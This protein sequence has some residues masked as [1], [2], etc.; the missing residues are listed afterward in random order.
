MIG[1]GAVP[2]WLGRALCA[3]PSPHG[4]RKVLVAI[5]Q[6]GAAD[7]LNIVVPFRDKQYYSLR[8]TIAIPQPGKQ[9]GALD[10]D[11]TCGL[12]P[13]MEPLRKLFVESRLAIV[14]GA[15][16][17]DPTR[18][19]FDAQD[20]MESGTPGRKATRD[21]WLNRSL[22]APDRSDSPLRAV[23]MGPRLP[24][25]LRGGNSAVAVADIR[26]F[27]VKEGDAAEMLEEM[28]SS[29]SDRGL[30]GPGKDTFEALKLLESIRKQP[31]TPAEGA[32][33]PAGRFG[34]SLQQI[35]RLI[36]AGAGVEV[37]FADLGGWDHHVNEPVQLGNLLR[38]FAGGLA[39]FY[40]DLG[41]AIEDVVVVTMSEFGRT[42]RENGNRGTDHGH[43]GVMLVMGGPVQ[44]G[45]MYGSLPGLE[46]EQLYEGRD[47]AVTTD[48]RQV[49]GEIV[50]GHLGRKDLGQVFPG[51]ALPSR[52]GVLK[53][54]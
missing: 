46:R 32:V 35:A 41:D 21:G 25:S 34:A 1:V 13:S 17:P 51:Y 40:H 53:S 39:A 31:Y 9:D 18:S 16:S 44:G 11:G 23:A 12:H 54:A 4:R 33:Y 15:G 48:F 20:Y 49:L 27:Q 37:A 42:A 52:L 6:R 24:R 28:Y 22:D 3:G 38:Q 43:G 50:A 7:A 19:H 8:P 30:A 2:G 5:F 47:L 26:E 29:T 36:K 14:H 10:L 45:K